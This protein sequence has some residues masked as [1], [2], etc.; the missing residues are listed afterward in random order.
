MNKSDPVVLQMAR[1]GDADVLARLVQLYAYDLSDVFGL[2]LGSDGR[3][4]YE[5]LPLYWSEPD[6]RFPLL[7][8]HGEA[9]AGFALVRLGSPVSDDPRVHDVAEFFVMRTHRR[10]GVGQRAAFQLWDR[11]PGPWTVR[12]SAANV[13]GLSFWSRAIDDYTGRM[14]KVSSQPG[15]PHTW[16]LHFFESASHD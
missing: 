3:Y 9:L 4:A 14:F 1:A 13:A 6:T 8:K 10:Y 5:Q 16:H 2:E 11:F 7:I 15:D 12:V